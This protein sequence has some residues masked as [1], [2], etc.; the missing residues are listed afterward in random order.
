MQKEHWVEQ[1]SIDSLYNLL[2]LGHVSFALDTS[3]PNIRLVNIWI[4]FTS[5]LDSILS[6]KTI[7]RQSIGCAYLFYYCHMRI[8]YTYMCHAI[9]QYIVCICFWENIPCICKICLIILF[10]YHSSIDLVLLWNKRRYV[11]ENKSEIK[12]N[13]NNST[14]D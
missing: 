1:N 12:E 11:N 10:R 14:I 9:P 3:Y 8:V 6:T 2:L 7:D 4:S 13:S 5:S